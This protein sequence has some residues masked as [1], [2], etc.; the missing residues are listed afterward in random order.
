MSCVEKF[1][2]DYLPVKTIFVT[3]F[4]PFVGKTNK[5][6]D[7]GRK[8]LRWLLLTTPLTAKTEYVKALVKRDKN[9]VLMPLKSLASDIEVWKNGGK[10]PDISSIFKDLPKNFKYVFLGCTHYGLMESDFKKVFPDAKIIS[11][12]ERAFEKIRFTLNTSDI[13][14]HKGSVAFIKS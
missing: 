13:G 12:E 2:G 10:K 1:A 14:D 6:S 4:S 9:V 3:P 7:C 8:G 11:G 5:S